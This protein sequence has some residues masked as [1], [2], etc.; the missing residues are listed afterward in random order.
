VVV[1]LK[2]QQERDMSLFLVDLKMTTSLRSN[3][4]NL[5]KIKLNRRF[6]SKDIDQNFDL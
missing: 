4:R 6:S 1:G 2:H 5:R 3:F